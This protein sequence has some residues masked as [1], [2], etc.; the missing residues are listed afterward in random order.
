VSFTRSTQL[1][2]LCDALT[3]W[4]IFFAILFGPWAFGT[5]QT[6]SIHV[7][8]GVGFALGLLWLVKL[9][10]RSAK[11]KAQSDPAPCASRERRFTRLLGAGTFCILLYCLVSAWNARVIYQ[12]DQWNFLYRPAILWLPHSYDQDSSW[13]AFW[14]YLALAGLFWALRDWLLGEK[15]YGLRTTDSEERSVVSGQW[16]VVS[17]SGRLPVRLRRLFWVLTANGTLLAIQGLMQRVEGGNRLL[18]L[19]VPHINNM[20]DAQFGPYAYRSNAA[21]YFNLLWPA[22]LGFWWAGVS[23]LRR[24]RVAAGSARQSQLAVLL[25]CVMIMAICPLVSSSRGG[26]IVLVGSLIMAGGIL[27][28]AQWR[29][30][31]RTKAGLLL[32]LAGVV[33]GGALLGWQ[34]LAPRMEQIHEGYEAREGLYL[35]GH[36]MAQDNAWFGTGPGTFATMYQL[37]FPGRLNDEDWLAQMHNDWLETLITFGRVGAAPIFLTLVLV[38]AH[39]FRGGGIYGNKNFVMLLWVA[40]GGCLV[41]AAFDFP[42]QV[43]SVLTLFLVLCA[44][45]SCLTQRESEVG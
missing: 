27:L 16:S 35:T 15:D 7:M 41:H 4:L 40:L 44:V 6:W 31:W 24:H 1:Y 23:S 38:L 17:S 39:W 14:K 8:N 11:R 20:A 42:F 43:H 13:S 21:Q 36:Y 34:T 45:L 28:Q 2:R 32:G 26:A 3:E 10:L 19:V 5:T 30:S 29:K 9:A 37:Y 12:P 22:V 33:C 25:P 18:W